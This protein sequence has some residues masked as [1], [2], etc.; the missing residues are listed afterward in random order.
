MIIEY[1]VSDRWQGRTLHLEGTTFRRTHAE[2][3]DRNEVIE[4]EG[5]APHV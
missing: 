1:R 2:T 5:V 3:Q 4:R